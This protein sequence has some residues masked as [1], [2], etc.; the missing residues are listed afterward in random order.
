MYCAA[1]VTV[2]YA[3]P[4]PGGGVVVYPPSGGRVVY[5]PSGG[6]AAATETPLWKFFAVAALGAL[7]AF[8][9][10]GLIASLRHR[11]ASEPS[12]MLRA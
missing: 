8:A 11:R 1:A 10:L 9:I 2:A 3:R 12:R 6:T 7:L 4:D 5:P